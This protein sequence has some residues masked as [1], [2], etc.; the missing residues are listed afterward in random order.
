MPALSAIDAVEII[1][2]DL[3][4]AS[5]MPGRTF[6]LSAHDCQ[7]GGKLHDVDDSTCSDCYAL[8]GRYVMGGVVDAHRARMEA[9]QAA[10]ASPAHSVLWVAAMAARI[11][12]TCKAVPYFRWHDSSDVQSVAHL[13]LIALVAEATPG[14]RQLASDARAGLRPALRRR[15]RR[16][17]GK[18]QRPTVGR[19][20][21]RRVAHDDRRLHDVRRSRPQ[22]ALGLR[23]PGAHAGQQLRRLPGM[24]VARR[25][26]R[27]L[28]PA[29]GRNGASRAVTGFRPV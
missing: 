24:L 8:K 1:G 5:K 21:R 7:T 19:D 12:S 9:L 29:L 22:G 11:R 2:T 10:L 23:L 27:H 4:R 18:P 17:P 16:L 25:R 15:A 14:V 28:S 6:G 20:A 3:G 26:A 13:R